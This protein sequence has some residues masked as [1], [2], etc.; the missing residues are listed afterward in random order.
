MVRGVARV[1]EDVAGMIGAAGC[2]AG[3]FQFF[4]ASPLQEV[5]EEVGKVLG[6]SCMNGGFP[7]FM[8]VATYFPGA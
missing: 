2:A 6:E 4:L 3:S 8:S 7:I 1:V 5:V